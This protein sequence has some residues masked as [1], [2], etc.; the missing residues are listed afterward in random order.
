MRT[1]RPLPEASMTREVV[2]SFQEAIA[3]IGLEMPGLRVEGFRTDGTSNYLA[4]LNFRGQTWAAALRLPAKGADISEFVSEKERAL[5]AVEYL[6]N[7]LG[8]GIQVNSNCVFTFGGVSC[9]V[10][11]KSVQEF[12]GYQNRSEPL[13]LIDN[14]KDRKKQ[15]TGVAYPESVSEDVRGYVQNYVGPFYLSRGAPAWETLEEYPNLE[16]S[17][18]YAIA[19]LHLL[20]GKGMPVP[21]KTAQAILAETQIAVQQACDQWVPAANSKEEA[22]LMKSLRKWNPNQDSE[23]I[24]F[25]RR[26]RFMRTST[27]K[28]ACRDIF[29]EAVRR[30]RLPKDALKSFCHGDCHGGNF[31][32]V[33][34]MY[35]LTDP[36][37]L[38]DRVFL[39]EIFEADPHIE[40]V[41]VTVDERNER[42]VYGVPEPGNATFTAHRKLHHEIH[43]ID[44]DAGQ[45]T[46]QNTKQLHL[47]DAVVY[48]MSL[49]N[50]TRLFAHPIPAREVLGHYY[51]GLER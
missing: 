18:A 1:S 22:A 26:E 34:Y 2:T 51:E 31:I 7:V 3:R 29:K 49:E 46:D 16:R 4:N 24:A 50:L 5:V 12:L 36:K 42:I 15:I 33:R 6:L 41:G 10:D 43:I 30:Q 13:T 39:N 38:L 19:A 20:T 21:F 37:V 14:I 8:R 35:T 45:G 40:S 28:S 11:G 17:V 32:I 9:L 25:I 48:A 44:L 47:Y 27:G 23:R